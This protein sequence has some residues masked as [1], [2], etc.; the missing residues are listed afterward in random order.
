MVRFEEAGDPAGTWAGVAWRV[1]PL[2]GLGG[3][4]AERFCKCM[5]RLPRAHGSHKAKARKIQLKMKGEK[6]S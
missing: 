3:R 1:V 6:G 2:D 5:G 4:G